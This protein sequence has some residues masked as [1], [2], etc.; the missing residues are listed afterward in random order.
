MIKITGRKKNEIR[1]C[2]MTVVSRAPALSREVGIGEIPHQPKHGLA[3][4]CL[5]LSSMG[6]LAFHN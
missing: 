2:L 5:L 6:K 1:G 3:E 4:R